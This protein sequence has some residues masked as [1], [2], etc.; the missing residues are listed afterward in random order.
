MGHAGKLLPPEGLPRTA[1]VQWVGESG[2]LL[3]SP[4]AQWG[5]GT[6]IYFL[7]DAGTAW[8][9]RAK[10]TLCDQSLLPTLCSDSP[11]YT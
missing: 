9:P 11:L 1:G 5:P 4:D 6:C 3:W 2:Y 8:P 10:P 7:K